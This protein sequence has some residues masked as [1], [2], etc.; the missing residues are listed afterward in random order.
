[1]CACFQRYRGTNWGSQESGEQFDSFN[2]PTPS[3]SLWTPIDWLTH[4][5]VA[6]CQLRIKVWLDRRTPSHTSL[7][8]SL[9]PDH[10][11]HPS[12]CPSAPTVSA[13]SNT[14]GRLQLTQAHLDVTQVNLKLILYTY[15]PT[16]T[17]PTLTL[18]HR[19]SRLIII[20]YDLSSTIIQN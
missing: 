1:M 18:N 2:L 15:I 5:T 14:T 17:I 10:Q 9:S 16:Q 6:S 8:L 11:H 19:C 4:S 3:E 12:W 20:N 13:Q 7:S